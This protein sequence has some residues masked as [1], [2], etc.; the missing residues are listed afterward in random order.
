MTLAFLCH[1]ERALPQAA[2]LGGKGA[3]APIS[4]DGGTQCNAGARLCPH[5]KNRSAVPRHCF[6][7]ASTQTLG[8]C[9]MSDI[10]KCIC[11]FVNPF[12]CWLCAGRND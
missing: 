12:K 3:R 6:V 1:E 2:E 9:L 4:E 11:C 8:Y 10:D 5:F 7:Y